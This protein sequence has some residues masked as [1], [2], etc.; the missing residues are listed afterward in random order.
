MS[1]V[2]IE[3]LSVCVSVRQCVP[4]GQGEIIAVRYAFSSGKQDAFFQATKIHKLVRMWGNCR[5][6]RRSD[7]LECDA[8]V[9][10]H[11]AGF[12]FRQCSV[13]SLSKCCIHWMLWPCDLL[14]PCEQMLCWNVCL[15]KD[16]IERFTNLCVILYI[17]LSFILFCYFVLLFFLFNF[18][19]L[20]LF[21]VIILIYCKK[22]LM[23]CY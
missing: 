18:F 21:K 7:W 16:K 3:C 15:K 14:W 5:R 13:L 1:E 19:F 23:K 11:S 10:N 4:A 9:A 6:I 20:I 2:W 12:A 17:C 8:I 22:M